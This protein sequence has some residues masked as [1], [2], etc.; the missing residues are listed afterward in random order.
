MN[1]VRIAG[2]QALYRCMCIGMVVVLLFAA[3]LPVAAANG[4]VTM[5]ELRGY[6]FPLE[7]VAAASSGH[8]AWTSERQGMRNIWV[9]SAPAYAPR[10]LTKY[11]DDNGQTLTGLHISTDGRRIVYVLGG[12][13]GG[14]WDPSVPINPTSLP[15]G[16]KVE[17]WSVDFDGGAP[18]R[19][20][21][22]DYPALSPDGTKVAFIR[23]GQ[24]W[25]VP[26]DGSGKAR[27]LFS[28]KG[29]VE[30]LV[31][32]PDGRALAFVADRGS[33]AL[34]G[35]YRDPKTPI[36]WMAPSIGRDG[37]PRWS[38]DSR[39]LLFARRLPVLGP[40]SS[41]AV[42]K[43]WAIVEAN[44]ET[45]AGR[46]RW[47]SG[48]TR[49]DSYPDGLLLEWAEGGRIVFSSYKDGWLHVYSLAPKA[50]EPQLLT[51]GD[52]QVEQMRLSNDRRS[53]IYMANTGP[54]P[55]DSERRHIFRVP[56][57]GSGPAV[58]LSGGTG[59]QWSPVEMQDRVICV[60]A[61]ARQPPLVAILQ[62][63]GS[64]RLIEKP[65]PDY[66]SS[67]LV[68]PHRVQFR[69]EDGNTVHAQ[70]FVPSRGRAPHPAIV[71]VHGGPQRQ[72]I[73]GWHYRNY[74]ANT[75]AINQ[76]LV[77][78]GFIV[79]SVN[80]RLGPG[81]GFDY[82]FPLGAGFEGGAEYR[83]VRAA[84]RY[85]RGRPDVDPDRIG[86]YG[87][88]YGGYLT[89]MALAHDSELFKAGVDIHGVH[90]WT[91]GNYKY[92]YDP[93]K[94]KS[95]KQADL[96]REAAWRASPVSAVDG[97]KSPVLFI[98]GDDDRNVR[99]EQTIDLVRHLDKNT[100]DYQVVLIPD[101]SH[102]MLRYANT[103]RVDEAIVRFF[104][105]HFGREA[106]TDP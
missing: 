92:L 17:V 86:I 36:A 94:Y 12:E 18:R 80:Y 97:W 81:Y 78:R 63:D 13:H 7:I 1:H 8:V 2:L 21:E 101:D 23:D 66:P 82:H 100:V 91:A 71:F 64:S 52:Y 75:Y 68:I 54:L 53:I 74:Y 20:G 87:G 26:S 56:V 10:R 28:T 45:G 24:P 47:H 70:L 95:R 16:M 43:P 35:V 89:A 32:S 44:P 76:Y 84:G 99:V 61:D 48:D 62:K 59:S 73:L 105:Q 41:L 39:H 60:T 31:W 85:L 93:H 79:L 57:D 55:D 22:G 106:P 51:P 67:R 49:R 50:A 65:Y 40:E 46:V 30:S 14:D 98:H 6:A 3:W 88:S 9:A 83:D 15:S 72:M 27:R 37:G 90:D 25:L 29:K 103:L 19:L 4:D 102:H 96:A 104:E 34:V 42:S 11:T 5:A 33:H 77:S 58:A 38:P 69:T